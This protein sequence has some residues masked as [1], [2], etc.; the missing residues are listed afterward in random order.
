M[1]TRR[2]YLYFVVTFVLGAVVGGCLSR[3]VLTRNTSPR[4]TFTDYG[5]RIQPQY[6]E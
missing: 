6:S 2:A 1:M 4:S 3:I 5:L